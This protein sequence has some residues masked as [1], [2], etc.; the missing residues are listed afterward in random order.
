ML[1]GG[2]VDLYLTFRRVITDSNHFAYMK[3]N[4][5]WN[6]EERKLQEVTERLAKSLNTKMVTEKMRERIRKS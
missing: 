3:R 5:S 2:L 4:P 6:I 1:S